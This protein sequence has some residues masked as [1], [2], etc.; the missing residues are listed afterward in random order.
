MMQ[1]HD[2]WKKKKIFVLHETDCTSEKDISS[3]FPLCL[4]QVREQ[5]KWL[6]D[7]NIDFSWTG[8][9]HCHHTRRVSVGRLRLCR[10]QGQPSNRFYEIM[11]DLNRRINNWTVF[12]FSFVLSL[13]DCKTLTCCS[14]AAVSL[15]LPLLIWPQ[16]S[17]T[18][19]DYIPL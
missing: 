12:F 1:W 3:L 9:H 6:M 15:F 5:Q 2:I 11:R 17:N 13:P 8:F 16:G 7:Q 18:W 10:P 4:I 19:D 14:D